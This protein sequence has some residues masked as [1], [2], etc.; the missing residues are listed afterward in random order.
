MDLINLRN[1]IDKIDDVILDLFLKRLDIA[2]DI[3]KYKTANSL[4]VLNAA[5]E[6]EI[7]DRILQS[8]DGNKAEYTAKLF[9]SIFEI[10]KEY[11]MLRSHENLI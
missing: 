10:S 3:A 4:P 6:T 1:E 9:S 7:L 2:E 8:T 5:R 11:Q